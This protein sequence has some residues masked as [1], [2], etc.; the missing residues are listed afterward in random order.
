[1]IR[2]WARVLLLSRIEQEP[3]APK[4]LR[5]VKPSPAGSLASCSLPRNLA[6]RPIAI[7]RPASGLFCATPVVKATEP[8][9]LLSETCDSAPRHRSSQSVIS[10]SAAAQSL[11]FHSSTLLPFPMTCAPSK[12]DVSRPRF[13]IGSRCGLALRLR[14]VSVLWAPDAFWLTPFSPVVCQAATLFALIVHPEKIGSLVKT[15]THRGRNRRQVT[16][17]KSVFG[18]ISL[19]RRTLPPPRIRGGNIPVVIG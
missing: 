16:R 11:H 3:S 13:L 17:T 4:A 10:A 12:G 19:W 1:M 2:T 14:L 8:T 7:K 9:R 6:S 18:R 5:P 15:G